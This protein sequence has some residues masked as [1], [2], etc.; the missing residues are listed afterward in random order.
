M[1]RY[2]KNNPIV[3]KAMGITGV[4]NKMPP[5]NAIELDVSYTYKNALV[6][7]VIFHY[8]YLK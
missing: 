7:Q 3:I 4:E 8:F 6:Y 5:C 2:R 1:L